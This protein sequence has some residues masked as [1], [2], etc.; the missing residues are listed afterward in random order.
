VVKGAV[1]VR[2]SSRLSSTDQFTHPWTEDLA[3]RQAHLTKGQTNG[4][5]CGATSSNN[6]RHQWLPLPD[7]RPQGPTRTNRKSWADQQLTHTHSLADQDQTTATTQSGLIRGSRLSWERAQRIA[8][9]LPAEDPNRTA[10]RITPRTML[11]GI[12][13]RTQMNVAGDRFEELREL[14]AAAGD[15]VSLAIAMAGLVLDRTLHGRVREASQL[16]S[17]TWILVES[18]GD[19]TL[20]VGLPVPMLYTKAHSGDWCDVL[21]WS[22]RLIDMADGDPSKGNF[23]V[24]CPLALAVAARAAARYCLGRPGWRDDLRHG[25]AMSRSTD[26][27]SY[28]TVV[29]WVYGAGISLGVLAADDRALCEIEDALQVAERSG[30][31]VA[32]SNARMT[33]GVALAHRQ[34]TA[35]RDRGQQVLAKV[36]QVLRRPGYNLCDLPIVEV[37]LARESARRGESDVAI[38]LMRAAVDQMVREGQLLGWGPPATGVLVETLLERGTENDRAE[39]EAA[40]ER[41]AAAPA[42]DGLVI[43]DIWLLRLRALLARARGDDAAYRDYR[44]RYRAMAESLGFEG[45][46]A[47]AEALIDGGE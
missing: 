40:I 12:A 35:D 26:A 45:H 29:A 2:L 18:I 27:M 10:M 20:T 28:A 16:A 21:R 4:F 36:S 43:R 31:D 47:M 44:D 30:D 9:A 46:T 11:C 32:L 3:S 17:E 1:V 25:L 15:K 33:L 38:P 42:D 23:M 37:Y 39:A 5:D 24:G 13:W 6:T 8:D 7:H 19:A 41:L 34:E 14:C 22:Q